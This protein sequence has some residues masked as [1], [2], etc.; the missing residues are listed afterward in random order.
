[1]GGGPRQTP[2]LQVSTC[3]IVS[4]RGHDCAILASQGIPAGMIFIRNDNATHNRDEAMNFDD[5]ACAVDVLTEWIKLT[6]EVYKIKDEK[7]Y[8]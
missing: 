2:F 1:M 8:K 6:L 5:F 3:S 7:S 4:G